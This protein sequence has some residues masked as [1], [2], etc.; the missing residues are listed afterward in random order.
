[1]LGLLAA[2]RTNDEIAAQLVLSPATVERHVANLY[3]KIGARRRAE[4]ATYAFNHGLLHRPPVSR[5][6]PAMRTLAAQYMV[7]R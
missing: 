3:R 2:G 7:P 5:T 1:V 4:A 6:C